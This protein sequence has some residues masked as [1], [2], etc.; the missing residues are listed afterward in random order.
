MAK[1]QEL[2]KTAAAGGLTGLLRVIPLLTALC[3]PAGFVSG[4]S[5][6]APSKAAAADRKTQNKQTRK[7][8]TKPGRSAPMGSDASAAG[9]FAKLRDRYRNGAINNRD[10][11]VGLTK[12][13]ERPEIDKQTKAKVLLAQS[14]ILARDSYPILASIYAA[15]A[16]NVNGDQPDKE[17]ERAW[18]ILW[19]A[20]A[21]SPIQNILEITE[22]TVKPPEAE[23]PLFG[24]NWHFIE[25]RVAQKAGDLN[26]AIKLFDQVG[27]SDKYFANAKFQS[28]LLRLDAGDSEGAMADFRAIIHPT[29]RKSMR[30]APGVGNE[31]VNN[32]RLALARVHYERREFDK[33]LQYYRSIGKDSP[34]FYDSL[35]EQAWAFFLAGYPNHALGAIH[36]AQSPFFKDAFNPE[37]DILRSIIFYWICDYDASRAT[38][39]KFISNHKQPVASLAEFLDKRRLT[40]ETAYQLF[41]DMVSGVSEASLGIPLNVLKTAA[42]KDSMM[43][44]RDQFAAFVEEQNR[45]KRK[46]VYGSK[47]GTENAQSYLERLITSI[48]R[49]L[50]VQFIA[51][52][53]AMKESY[54][55]LYY[56]SE[57]L[58]V[59]LLMS[60]KEKILGKELHASS[61]ITAASSDSEKV[62]GWSSDNRTWDQSSRNEFWWDEV[63]YYVYQAKP[64]CNTLN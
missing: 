14:N 32:A 3:L 25:G 50:G 30:H 43:Q 10:M 48:K 52:F 47:V 55:D 58:Y 9:A 17:M 57:F 20:S 2:K 39:A 44:I 35:T 23:P 6:A 37:M 60:Q 11:W 18:K 19:D 42:S 5:W 29:T 38:L 45:L 33:A 61:K 13:N 56:Q 54:D 34:A 22:S 27:M 53:K 59:E 40:P 1:K 15:Q 64:E 21:G 8:E 49:D 12:L 24:S 36:G 31:L 62:K 46:G 4:T 41:E 28:A 63:G 26:N 51:E 7:K 16:L